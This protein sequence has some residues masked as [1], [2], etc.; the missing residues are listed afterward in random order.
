MNDLKNLETLKPYG[1]FSTHKD[2]LTV[3]LPVP[4]L[5]FDRHSKLDP[6][7]ISSNH[8][9]AILINVTDQTTSYRT[10]EKPTHVM[11]RQY[12]I[13]DVFKDD[14]DLTAHQ[15]LLVIVY[16]TKNEFTDT[17]VDQIKNCVESITDY[18]DYEQVLSCLDN[19]RKDD[20]TDENIIRPNEKKGN[21]LKGL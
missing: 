21:I 1:G 20:N 5:D 12:K 2:N 18:K 17:E 8:I 7:N 6:I 10:D 13:S 15:A 11:Q 9:N 4:N 14:T 3:F 19:V 16:N